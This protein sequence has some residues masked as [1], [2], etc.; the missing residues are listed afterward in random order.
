MLPR[1]LRLGTLLRRLGG[2]AVVQR[3]SRRIKIGIE[4][5]EHLPPAASTTAAIGRAS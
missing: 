4:R 2:N 3:F 5:F 1:S